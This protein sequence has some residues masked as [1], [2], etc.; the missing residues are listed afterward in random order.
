MAVVLS[1]SVAAEQTEIVD[2][3]S[4]L[5]KAELEQ[6]ASFLL[7]LNADLHVLVERHRFRLGRSFSYVVPS[8]LSFLCISG[9]LFDV[10]MN[11]TLWSV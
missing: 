11:V 4:A 3:V 7:V 2:P 5:A 1:S 10:S 6:T 8:N 9:K